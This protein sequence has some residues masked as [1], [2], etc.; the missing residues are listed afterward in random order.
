MGKK[1]NNSS[2][3]DEQPGFNEFLLKEYDNIAQAHFNTKQTLT[4]FFRYYLLIVAL[5]L[6]FIALFIDKVARAEASSSIQQSLILA[7]AD[8]SPFLS[9][10]IGLI[11]IFVMLY[12]ANLH[13]EALLYARQVNGIRWYFYKRAKGK[14]H[15]YIENISV[16]PIDKTK[17]KA[18][19]KHSF[20]YVVWV[21]IIIDTLYFLYPIYHCLNGSQKLLCAMII[22]SFVVIVV[23][24]F[25]HKKIFKFNAK[26]YE[27]KWQSMF[28]ASLL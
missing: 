28:D 17:P 13:F 10:T 11:G 16:L 27:E 21:F 24:I 22:L 4:T 14:G 9:F 3:I 23:S 26:R 12:M 8:L 25:V 15:T 19:G 6:P 20:S 5:P 1:E 18:G 2:G 7:A